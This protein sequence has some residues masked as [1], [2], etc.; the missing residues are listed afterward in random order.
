MCS[1]TQ[2]ISFNGQEIKLTG[3]RFY[4]L[5]LLAAQK[6]HNHAD[7]WIRVGFMSMNPTEAKRFENAWSKAEDNGLTVTLGGSSSKHKSGKDVP[8]E[9]KPAYWSKTVSPL[10]TNINKDSVIS[11]VVSH[12][13]NAGDGLVVSRDT[14]EF[15]EKDGPAQKA[16]KISDRVTVEICN[17]GGNTKDL[18]IVD[19]G[20]KQLPA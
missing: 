15:G 19:S 9:E 17:F 1:S 11:A 4:L 3:Q 13:P 18:V 20:F 16:F 12:T 6:K 2:K 14:G 7:G 8:K 10:M 5:L